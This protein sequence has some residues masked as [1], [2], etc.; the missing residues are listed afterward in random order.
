MD[1]Q[2]EVVVFLRHESNFNVPPIEMRSNTLHDSTSTQSLSLHNVVSAE[3]LEGNSY[4]KKLQKTMSKLSRGSSDATHSFEQNKLSERLAEPK[5]LTNKFQGENSP[6]KNNRPSNNNDLAD[7]DVIANSRSTKVRPKSAFVQRHRDQFLDKEFSDRRSSKIPV[8]QAGVKR[9]T[10]M[11]KSSDRAQFGKSNIRTK[12][13]LPNMQN[14]D[15]YFINSIDEDFEEKTDTNINDYKSSFL[16]LSSAVPLKHSPHGPNLGEAQFQQNT[17]I[18]SKGNSVNEQVSASNSFMSV[19]SKKSDQ[20]SLVGSSSSKS[21]ILFV[22]GP[23]P[24]AYKS[25]QMGR[26]SVMHKTG[27]PIAVPDGSGRVVVYSNK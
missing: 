6:V 21:E 19:Q 23:P 16:L 24:T 18:P 15:S 5:R 14:H 4:Y 9:T 17:E 22:D 25:K 1:S 27:I 8:S 7:S 3:S 26:I 2:R 11:K 12:K 10:S 13:E 20:G